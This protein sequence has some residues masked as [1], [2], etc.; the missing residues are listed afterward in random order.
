MT[1]AAF[2]RSTENDFVLDQVRNQLD[3]RHP[4]LRVRTRDNLS[5]SEAVFVGEY[6]D[7]RRI[8]ESFGGRV[9]F[10]GSYTDNSYPLDSGEGA[11]RSAFLAAGRLA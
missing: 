2:P 3:L 4:P 1:L 9:Y 8:E 10:A 11:C 5:R 6:V 7:P